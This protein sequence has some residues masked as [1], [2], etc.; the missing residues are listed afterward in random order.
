MR[1]AVPPAAGA[2]LGGRSWDLS[3]VIERGPGDEGVIVATGNENAGLSLFIL[4]DR[5][6][7][8]YNI[9]G[10]HHV[11]E[12]AVEVPTGQCVVG[13]RSAADAVTPT[14]R[15]WSTAATRARCTCRS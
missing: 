2:T 3:A 8:D 10:E 5:L 6:V 12:S 4:G 9:F 15:S 13:A 1:A 7:F 11:I 14:S